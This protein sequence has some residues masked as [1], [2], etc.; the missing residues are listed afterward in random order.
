MAT[1][2]GGVRAPAEDPVI[3]RIRSLPKR[4]LSASVNGLAGVWELRI[5]ERAFA[6]SVVAGDCHVLEGPAVAP[7][8]TISTDAATWL[9]MDE[10]AVMG[11]EAFLDRRLRVGGNLD[12]AVRLQSLFRPHGRAVRASDLRQVDVEVEGARVST[13]QVGTG[14]PLLLLHGLGG[15]KISWLPI[16]PELAR[17]Y[18]LVIPDL[19]GHGESD[20]LRTDYSMRTYAHLVRVLMDATD[21]PRAIVVGNS[22]GGRI[23]LELALRSA[24]RVAGLALLD[25]ALPGLRW[26]Y[27]AGFTR[28]FPTEFGPLSFPLRRRWMEAAVRGLFAHP[29]RLPKEAIAAAADE[30]IRIYSGPAARLAFASSLRHLVTE[31]PGPFW[32]S[33]RRVRQPSLVVFG[34]RDRLV[35]ARFG[36]ELAAHLHDCELHFLHEV[37]HVPQ[38]EATEQTVRLLSP[39]LERVAA[40]GV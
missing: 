23:A 34:D 4:F 21:L 7:N 6:V 9:A 28:V 15:T 14:P 8:A 39:F 19:P 25:P 10:G 37:G 5:D 13:Y 2:P 29:E 40:A 30:F 26:R 24:Q 1:T 38:F 27:L 31:R 20:K 17:S 22:M 11:I 18:R 16:V 33:M 32:A 12:L 36:A 35:P 3:R